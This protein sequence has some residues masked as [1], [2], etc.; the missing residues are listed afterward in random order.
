MSSVKIWTSL[1]VLL[2]L[3]REI[4]RENAKVKWSSGFLS[5]KQSWK[6]HYILEASFLSLKLL[7]KVPLLLPQSDRNSLSL[8]LDIIAWYFDMTWE[9]REFGLDGRKK[10]L[11]AVTFHC[12]TWSHLDL[13]ALIKHLNQ[14]RDRR[15]HRQDQSHLAAEDAIVRPG[16]VAPGRPTDGHRHS[17]I[18]TDTSLCEAGRA[19]L[20]LDD[21]FDWHQYNTQ[22]SLWRRFGKFRMLCTSLDCSG[23][24]SV[25]SKED[26]L[27]VLL[28]DRQKLSTG[29]LSEVTS[30]I[31]IQNE[32]PQL[33]HMDLSREENYFLQIP[34]NYYI[35]FIAGIWKVLVFS[36]NL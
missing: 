4:S 35:S 14:P 15:H 7:M 26:Q 3:L 1:L 2:A 6:T 12:K 20:R 9:T 28:A 8:S 10:F 29:N 5:S 23:F 22:P 13:L 32:S 34:S 27:R 11:T 16:L 31:V 21:K 18:N 17:G 30:G 33:F 24:I 19:W 25:R 36:F